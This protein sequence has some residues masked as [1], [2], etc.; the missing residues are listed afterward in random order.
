MIQTEPD[1]HR[2][3]ALPP[4]G[5]FDRKLQ[6]NT[7]VINTEHYGSVP[8]KSFSSSPTCW[9]QFTALLAL[10]LTPVFMLT[11][12]PWHFCS[13]EF[14]ET[15][16]LAASLDRLHPA[17]SIAGEFQ[18]LARC[19]PAWR[20]DSDEKMRLSFQQDRTKRKQTF[21][22]DR[23]PLQICDIW[24]F[25]SNMNSSNCEN[26]IFILMDS[27]TLLDCVRRRRSPWRSQLSS[28]LLRSDVRSQWCHPWTCVSCGCRL[29]LSSGSSVLPASHSY[30]LLY[31]AHGWITVNISWP[32]DVFL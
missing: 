31:V 8:S 4:G 6:V 16:D 26:Q 18:R 15:D 19:F 14:A 28:V 3:N 2:L 21:D 12:L 23:F 9:P 1:Q 32:E 25:M 22:N 20:V 27:W 13:P 10:L 11:W 30:F 29:K 24:T 7:G 5:H 17:Q